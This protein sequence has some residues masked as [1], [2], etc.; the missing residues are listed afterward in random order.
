MKY[1]EP[2]AH[3]IKRLRL[4]RAARQ[5]AC[6]SAAVAE[7]ARAAGYPNLP[8]F[9]RSFKSIYGLPPARFRADGQHRDFELRP[10]ASHAPAFE[11]TVLHT[12]TWA[13][14]TLAH[15]GS[16]MLIGRTFALLFTRLAAAGLVRP[17]M[18]MLTRYFDDPDLVA[19]SALRAQAAVA[20][21]AEPASDAG[22]SVK[23]T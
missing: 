11:V 5:L 8:S 19:E 6:S 20:G 16:C 15:R 7:V 2:L 17:G 21:F 13:V 4:H 22:P 9:N 12:E 10:E 14:L 1:G 3:T 18:R 23:R